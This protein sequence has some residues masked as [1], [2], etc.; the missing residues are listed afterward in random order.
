MQRHQLSFLRLGT[1]DAES[2]IL[3]LFSLSVFLA[4]I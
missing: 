3:I 2:L 4:L 1:A